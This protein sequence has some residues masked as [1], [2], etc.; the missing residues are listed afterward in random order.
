MPS[1]K[2]FV[3]GG[4]GLLGKYVVAELSRNFEVMFTYKTNSCAIK[5]AKAV[6]LDLQDAIQTREVIKSFNPDIIIHAAAV[7]RPEL[8]DSLSSKTVYDI[9]VNAAERLAVLCAE[10]NSKL[11]YYST[12]LVYDGR[13]G[14]M[15]EEN[16]KLNPITLYAETKLMGEIKI[17]ETF[18][19][20]II[21]RTA[22][23]YGF[24]QSQPNNNFHKM[25]NS[26][27]KGENVKL[28]IDQFRTPLSL[29]EAAR[30]TKELIYKN[31]KGEIINFGGID[32]ISRL[33]LGEILCEEG[34]FDKKLIIPISMKDLPGFPMV[35]DVSMSVNKLLA[36]GIHLKDTRGSVREILINVV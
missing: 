19:N 18:K 31:I 28:F 29:F 23:L 34:N 24:S 12:D 7:S 13:R 35:S 5:N 16:G 32:R 21:L 3:T 14:S 6:H 27:L 4:S 8:A 25:Y 15:I 30:I 10:L 2:V 20:Y 1:V 17:K 11:I 33:Q 9:N 22:L 36:M 26:F